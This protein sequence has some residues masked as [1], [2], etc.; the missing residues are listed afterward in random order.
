MSFSGVR[1]LACGKKVPNVPAG[2]GEITADFDAVAV[3]GDL[4]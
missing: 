1:F 3:L 2:S 4:A